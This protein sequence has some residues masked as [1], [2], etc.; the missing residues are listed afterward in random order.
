MPADRRNLDLRPLRDAVSAARGAP[1]THISA[2]DVSTPAPDKG[3]RKKHH[4]IPVFYLK[5]WTAQDGRLWE[6]SRPYKTP[7]GQPKPDIKSIPVKA[8]HTYPDATGFIKN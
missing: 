6:F 4:Y 8:R 7:E 3:Q 1:I 5:K 2:A